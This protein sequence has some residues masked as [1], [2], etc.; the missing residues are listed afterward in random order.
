[1]PAE[2]ADWLETN[3][4]G[5]DQVMPEDET[6][7]HDE[8]MAGDAYPRPASSA[9]LH[10]VAI[11]AAAEGRLDIL[12]WLQAHQAAAFDHRVS[13]CLRCNNHR[14]P[15]HWDPTHSLDVGSLFKGAWFHLQSQG[16][17]SAEEVSAG[18]EVA[19]QED[20]LSHPKTRSWL[21]QQKLPAAQV[22]KSHDNLA[23]VLVRLCKASTWHIE[24]L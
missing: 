18:E 7:S 23:G 6:C 10:A 24:I 19:D 22:L 2:W 11:P 20:H 4:S 16:K 14:K 3:A 13:L 12:Q 15:C 9:E 5:C 1:M 17:H 8:G 21:W